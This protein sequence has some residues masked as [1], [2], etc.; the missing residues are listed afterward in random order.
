MPSNVEERKGNKFYA[1]DANENEKVIVW[2]VITTGRA[3]GEESLS[4]T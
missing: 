3:E 1:E 2:S 4:N